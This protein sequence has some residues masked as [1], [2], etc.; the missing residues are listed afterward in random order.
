METKTL[1][2]RAQR[3]RQLIVDSFNELLIAKNFNQIAIK[4]ITD[5]ATINRA[6]F[7]AHFQD[8]Y[9][10]LDQMLTETILNGMRE[11]LTCHEVLNEQTIAQMIQSIVK[12]HDGMH[13]NCRKGYNTFTK[14]IEEKTILLLTE[15]ISRLLGSE[16]KTNKAAIISWAIYGAFH[17]WDNY[18][19]IPLEEHAKTSAKEI[20]KLI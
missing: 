3:T 13:E 5:K 9:D 14:M 8:K 6:T 20:S 10:L 17:F 16:E 18:L 2:P 11:H 1:D 4:D 12:I 15:T 7:Y 19:P